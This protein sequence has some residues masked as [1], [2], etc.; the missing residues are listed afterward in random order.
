MVMH[1][2]SDSCFCADSWA[3][4]CSN[5]SSS[6]AMRS[7]CADSWAI[8]SESGFSYEGF[9]SGLL[10]E[11]HFALAAC[12]PCFDACFCYW[13]DAHLFSEYSH[14]C[15]CPWKKNDFESDSSCAPCSC[16][17]C[18]G[19]APFDWLFGRHVWAIRF[20]NDFCFGNG[21]SCAPCSCAVCLDDDFCYWHDARHAFEIRFSSGF[22]SDFCV[23]ASRF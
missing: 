12:A 3:I 19:N 7:S 2:W 4:C 20:W 15:D 18:F 23:H 1:S 6:W 21:S 13:P 8:C 17:V 16:V 5:D 9:L 11:R 22:W 14:D 10:L